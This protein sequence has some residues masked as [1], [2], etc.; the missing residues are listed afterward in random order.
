MYIMSFRKANK[1]FRTT[2]HTTKAQLNLL[3]QLYEQLY[4]SCGKDQ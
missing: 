4:E 1:P 3:K 2:A